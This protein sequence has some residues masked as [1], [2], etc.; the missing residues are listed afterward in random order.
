MPNIAKV[1]KEE[2]T[3]LARKEVRTALE[4]ASRATAQ[5]RREIVNLK[6]Q[7]AALKRQV[8]ALEKQ[9]QKIG[10]A[11]EAAAALR[12]IRFVPKGLIA[13]RK[14][15][16]LSAADLAKMLG[17][18]AQ[19]IYNW[20]R[21]VTKPGADQQAKIASLRGVGKRQVRAQLEGS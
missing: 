20:E 5:H 14:R 13:T 6:S 16:G 10:V 4:K 9:A 17:V 15:L 2:I 8:A 3:R 12:R 18:S 21:G 7:V 1:L 19:T 11:P